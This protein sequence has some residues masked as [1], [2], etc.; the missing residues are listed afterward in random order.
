M[1]KKPPLPPHNGAGQKLR[2]FIPLDDLVVGE[3]Y[4]LES[5][6]LRRGV[7][8]GKHFHG[9]RLKFGSLFMDEEVHWDLD[10]HY[11]TAQATRKLE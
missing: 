7:W 3:C 5:R 4:E 10:D 1:D 9:I 8:D 6:N 11:G 2:D